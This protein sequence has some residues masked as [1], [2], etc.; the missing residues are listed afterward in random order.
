VCVEIIT[1]G[2][3]HLPQASD[4][5]VAVTNVFVHVHVHVRAPLY[6]HNHS[7]LLC[8]ES[9]IPLDREGKSHWC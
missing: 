2:A 9:L 7:V 4:S 5:V 1:R 8:R 6:T 3:W